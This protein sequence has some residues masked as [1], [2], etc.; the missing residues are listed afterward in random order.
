MVPNS[1]FEKHF[2]IIKKGEN[3]MENQ[4]ASSLEIWKI[5][6]IIWKIV[7]TKYTYILLQNNLPYHNKDISYHKS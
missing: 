5:E 3:I 1:N 7:A 2:V 6:W 4:L